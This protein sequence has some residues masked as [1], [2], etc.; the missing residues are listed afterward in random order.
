[1]A[2]LAATRVE[3][4]VRVRPQLPGALMVLRYLGS[5]TFYSNCCVCGLVGGAGISSS[6]QQTEQSSEENVEW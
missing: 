5:P 4:S 1:M 3:G 2:E 6:A